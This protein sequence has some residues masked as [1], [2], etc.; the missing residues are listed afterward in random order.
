MKGGGLGS[1]KPKKASPK[2]QTVKKIK[3]VRFPENP[4]SDVRN[5]SPQEKMDYYKKDPNIKNRK[6]NRSQ[7]KKA[8]R[9][10]IA[11]YNNRQ[12]EIDRRQYLEDFALG[13]VKG[14]K[15]RSIRKCRLHKSIKN[16]SRTRIRRGGTKNI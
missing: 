1:S 15:G 4:V 7:T 9:K 11:D 3:V 16:K 5:M 6:V 2:A 8:R 10:S 14:G 13:K 12:Y